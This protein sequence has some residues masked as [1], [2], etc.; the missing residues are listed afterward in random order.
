[1]IQSTP[2]TVH[3]SDSPSESYLSVFLNVHQYKDQF[4]AYPVAVVKNDKG[5]LMQCKLS[6]VEV[7]VPHGVPC[8][9]IYKDADYMSIFMGTFD[10]SNGEESYPV[11]VVRN[12]EG[13]LQAI[14]LGAVHFLSSVY[15]FEKKPNQSHKLEA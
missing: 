4:G 7:D 13:R 8:R 6:A 3:P 5:R 11:A 14:R 10:F 9:I 15:L 1:M 2:C 12:Q